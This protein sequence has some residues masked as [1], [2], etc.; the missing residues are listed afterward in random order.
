M[1][2]CCVII[3]SFLLQSNSDLVRYLDRSIKRTVATSVLKSFN[4]RPLDLR[5]SVEDE[6][7]Q[8]A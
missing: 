1:K 3:I 6:S 8:Y 5:H 2:N 7:A 4:V